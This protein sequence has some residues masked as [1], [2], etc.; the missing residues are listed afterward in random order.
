MHN[1]NENR[2]CEKNMPAWRTETG[3]CYCGKTSVPKKVVPNLEEVTKRLL[4][5]E[6]NRFRNH[7]SAM[8]HIKVGVTKSRWINFYLVNFFDSMKWPYFQKHVT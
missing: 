2:V 1:F 7:F 6:L 3:I 4:H 8:S 5:Q